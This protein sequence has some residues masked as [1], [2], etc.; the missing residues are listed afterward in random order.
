LPPRRFAFVKRIP[1]RLGF[2]KKRTPALEALICS[3]FTTAFICYLGQANGWSNSRRQLMRQSNQGT[4]L[5]LRIAVERAV[6]TA[7]GR[8]VLEVKLMNVG[9]TPVDLGKNIGPGSELS[10]A[11]RDASGKLVPLNLRTLDARLHVTPARSR[12]P[13]DFVRLYPG[14]F[15]GVRLALRC[16]DYGLTVP[17]KYSV[18]VTYEATDNG[19]AAGI[20]AFDGV[21]KSN[22]VFFKISS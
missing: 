5:A 16:R 19:G 7:L 22:K 10:L 2:V 17:G 20:K 9:K 4:E 14:F 15:Y 13:R 12:N 1:S 3:L 18:V 6:R 21:L 11:F 8:V